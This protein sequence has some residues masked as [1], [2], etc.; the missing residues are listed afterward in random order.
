MNG[1]MKIL[2]VENTM[3]VNIK[4]LYPNPTDGISYLTL[5]SK[6]PSIAKVNIYA[7]DGRMIA[8]S[9]KELT[10]G[11]NNL[12]LDLTNIEP[13]MYFVEVISKNERVTAKLM[14]K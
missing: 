1:G 4:N 14:I 2:G 13:G 6:L 12:R 9:N 3:N 5:N 11:E 7:I 8:Q 10:Q